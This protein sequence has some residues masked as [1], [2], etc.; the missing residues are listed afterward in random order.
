MQ[1]SRLYGCGNYIH[2]ESPGFTQ[3]GAALPAGEGDFK[4][5]AT[6]NNRKLCL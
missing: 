2:E 6:E 3:Q 4:E 5:S 1:A